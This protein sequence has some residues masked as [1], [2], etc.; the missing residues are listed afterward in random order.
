MSSGKLTLAGGTIMRPPNY[1]LIGLIVAYSAAITVARGSSAPGASPS[2][3]DQIVRV[4]TVS[5]DGIERGAHDLLE[6]TIAR[7]NLAAS[8][9]P[10]IACLPELFSN[11]APESVPGPVTERLA[12]WA[13]EHSSYLIFGLETKNGDRNV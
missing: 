7:L 13:R 3:R 4:V 8:F 5:Q 10:D 12:A 2:N 9:H 11:R 6:S 1:S